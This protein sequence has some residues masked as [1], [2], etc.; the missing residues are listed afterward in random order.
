M[1]QVA[2]QE[3][4]YESYKENEVRRLALERDMNC[5]GDDRKRKE[6]DQIDRVRGIP[7]S[8]AYSRRD[9]IQSARIEACCTINEHGR[10]YAGPQNRVANGSRH[11]NTSHGRRQLE[12]R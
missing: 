8:I 1:T 7:E 5:A 11:G 10:G 2:N 9:S 6:L 12:H 4:A 3:R